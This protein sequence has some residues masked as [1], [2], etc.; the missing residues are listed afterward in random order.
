MSTI[1]VE[2][3][4]KFAR[5]YR[6]HQVR[7]ICRI[8]IPKYLSNWKDLVTI[9]LAVCLLLMLCMEPIL[10]CWAYTV[11]VEGPFADE[12]CEKAEEV[13]TPYS[14]FSMSAMFIY[15]FLLVDLSVFSTRI[16]AYVLVCGRMFPEVA[17]CL[18]ALATV[19][20]T[21]A[22]ATSTLEQTNNDFRIIQNGCLNFFEMIMRMYSGEGY[23]K[24]HEDP[25]LLLVV[26]CFLAFSIFFLLNMLIAQLN[27]AYDFIYEDMVGFARLKRAKVIIETMPQVGPK[28]WA[29][30]RNTLKFDRKLEFGEGDEGLAGGL[31]VLEPAQ[32]NL[33]KHDQIKRHGGSTSVTSPWPA[34]EVEDE[35]DR[36]DRLEAIMKKALDKVARKSHKGEDSQQMSGSGGSSNA[37]GASAD[38]LQDSEHSSQGQNAS[39]LDE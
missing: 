14:L 17:L 32:E 39:Q 5:A 23:D 33:V 1:L 20:I 24:L 36:F 34:E 13:R 10:R 8:P 27:F 6:F 31:Q 4:I 11:D 37:S 28:R 22:A 18:A 3:T 30:F 12:K 7:P 2:H 35:A 15:F 29:N 26:Y 25:V 16:S 21:C 9:T 19:I 38:I